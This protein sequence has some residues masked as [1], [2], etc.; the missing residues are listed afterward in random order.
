[1]NEAA[2]EVSK[3]GAQKL[4]ATSPKKTGKYA[5][6][7]KVKKVGTKWVTYNT[8]YRLTHLLEKGHAKVNGGRVPAKVHIAP[9]EQDMIEE[10][11]RKTEE[12]IRG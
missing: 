6:S 10:F 9:V 1:V 7:W 4:K 2:Q 12:A 11:T 3:D 8:R 5:T